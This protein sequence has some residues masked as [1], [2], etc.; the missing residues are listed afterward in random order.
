MFQQGIGSNSYS[1]NL[2]KKLKAKLTDVIKMCLHYQSTLQNTSRQVNSTQDENGK[3]CRHCE[4]F[5]ENKPNIKQVCV[6][7]QSRRLRQIIQT[8]GFDKSWY[9][10][11]T[12]FNNCFIIHFFNNRQKKTFICW[13]M[14]LFQN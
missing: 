11:K 9:H 4:K 1:N 3:P 6:I 10:A 5:W 2:E 12:E 7:C 8:W 13:K 14:A